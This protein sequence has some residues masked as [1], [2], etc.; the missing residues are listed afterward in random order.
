MLFSI[1]LKPNISEGICCPGEFNWL[2]K[3]SRAQIAS[4]IFNI[5]LKPIKYTYLCTYAFVNV[6]IV[7]TIKS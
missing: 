4:D 7:K 2:A 5:T 1:S 3:F 6:K